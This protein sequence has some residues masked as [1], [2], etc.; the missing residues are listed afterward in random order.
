MLWKW[1]QI[2]C[3]TPGLPN[4]ACGKM[5]QCNLQSCHMHLCL[6]ALNAPSC[7]AML[8]HIYCVMKLY[9]YDANLCEKPIWPYKDLSRPAILNLVTI[10]VVVLR[11]TMW[12]D[13][14]KDV[15]CP[16]VFSLYTLCKECTVS[17]YIFT[18]RIWHLHF[19]HNPQYIDTL[20]GDW[21]HCRKHFLHTC[22]EYRD[23]HK[24]L[25]LG[26][27]SDCLDNHHQTYMLDVLLL[28]HNDSAQLLSQK[29]T[30]LFF[31]FHLLLKV[32]KFPV[33]YSHYGLY[34]YMPT[35]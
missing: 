30:M 5:E 12:L 32:F 19:R 9:F 13:K 27:S 29:T 10:H 11:R 33:L 35:H 1:I 34:Q 14:E 6:D 15:T 17:T 24:Y 21:K 20:L 25:S 7:S 28:K 18:Y 31:V 16:R 4:P 23:H 8:V 2:L 22:F 26:C 3:Y